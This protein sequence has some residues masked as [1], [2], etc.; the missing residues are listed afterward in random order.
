[1]KSA[2]WSGKGTI[3]GQANNQQL[4]IWAKIEKVYSLA[5]ETSRSRAELTARSA[6]NMR[7]ICATFV[8]F[9][10]TDKYCEEK[11]KCWLSSC[12]CIREKVAWFEKVHC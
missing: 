8:R 1:M 12:L 6:R 9:A 2:H 5:Q 3:D 10:R 7:E 4:G 11:A